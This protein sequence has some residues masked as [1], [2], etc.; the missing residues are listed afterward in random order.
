MTRE[1]VGELNDA[2]VAYLERCTTPHGPRLLQALA[3]AIGKD[4]SRRPGPRPR[5][6]VKEPGFNAKEGRQEAPQG[7]ATKI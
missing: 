3:N 4:P 7:V 6:L 5:A 1:E 2:Q